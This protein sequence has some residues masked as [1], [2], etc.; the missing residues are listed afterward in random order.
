MPLANKEQKLA[1][2][3]PL[4]DP[5]P[6]HESAGGPHYDKVS[7]VESL[8]TVPSDEAAL[9]HPRQGLLQDIQD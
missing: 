9:R 3:W 2:S 1:G 5:R 6:V 7:Q 8:G 4:V